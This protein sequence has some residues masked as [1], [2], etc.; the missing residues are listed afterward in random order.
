MYSLFSKLL[1]FDTPLATC[2][3]F[4]PDKYVYQRF[5]T[6]YWDQCFSTRF[7]LFSF[8]Y[9]KGLTQMLNSL[10]VEQTH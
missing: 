10:T 7:I 1:G 6:L 2:F 3:V 9:S 8:F 4:I 5:T